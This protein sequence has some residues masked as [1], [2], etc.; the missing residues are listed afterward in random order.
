MKMGFTRWCLLAAWLW[1]MP[2]CAGPDE[3]WQA[4][5]AFW[6]E[7]AGGMKR[8]VASLRLWKA[9]DDAYVFVPDGGH[10]FVWVGETDGQCAVLG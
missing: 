7:K 4:A 1:A 8:G 6:Q 2:V 9:S 10:G 5:L 3:A